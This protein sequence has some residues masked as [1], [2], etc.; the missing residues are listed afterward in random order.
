MT[1]KNTIRL[2]SL[3]SAAIVLCLSGCGAPPAS[4]QLST[5]TRHRSGDMEQLAHSGNIWI[6]EQPTE[7]DFLWMR[8]NAVSLVLD[9]RPRDVDPEML[10]R[11]YVISLGMG[12]QAVPLAVDQDYVIRYF[13]FIRNILVT[14]KNIPTL[15]HG[16]TADRAAAVWMVFRVLDDNIAYPIALAEAEIAGLESESTLLLVQ[17]YLMGQ[18]IDVRLDAGLDG[19][20]PMAAQEGADEVIHVPAADSDQAADATE[21]DASE[22]S[23]RD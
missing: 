21:S 20:A 12:Y 10:E 6:S 9:V 13:D 23:R 14:R 17:Q 8:D 19:A 16:V 3:V 15:I 5:I 2:S 18:G 11:A 7:A 1:I 22:D 4:T